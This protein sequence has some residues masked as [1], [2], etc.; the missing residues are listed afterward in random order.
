MSSFPLSRALRSPRALHL[1][2]ALAVVPLLG[3]SVASA[4]IYDVTLT[5]TV[6]FFDEP[7]PY[8][9]NDPFPADPGDSFTLTFQVD[10]QAAQTSTNGTTISEYGSAVSNFSLT[11]ENGLAASATSDGVLAADNGSSHQWSLFADNGSPGFTSNFPDPLSVYDELLDE[12]QDFFFFSI[13]VFLFDNTASA[14]ALSPPELV[15]PTPAVFTNQNVSVVWAGG[16]GGGPPGQV[17]LVLD[18]TGFTATPVGGPAVPA[19]GL[20]A[21][22]L[23]LAGLT[24]IGGAGLARRAR[25]DARR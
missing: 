25:G 12:D 11:I 22:G 5:G 10:D 4:V 23:L 13:D 20:P 14:Y 3:P 16:G 6:Q 9:L 18:V 1:L 15:A 24:A 7:F 21:A 19:L 2:V 17:S 8:T